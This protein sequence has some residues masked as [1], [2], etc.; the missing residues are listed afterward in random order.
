MCLL[1]FLKIGVTNAI[2][3]SDGNIP[4]L[5]D[6]LIIRERGID[7]CCDICFSREIDSLSWPELFFGFRLLKIFCITSWLI[8]LN[9]NLQLM[10]FLRYDLNE[11]L[12]ALLI[13]LASLGPIVEKY[14]LNLLAISALS[15][16][17]V[18]LYIKYDGKSHFLVVLFRREFI[19]PHVF[20]TLS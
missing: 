14:S 2:L 13:L 7:M 5:R 15:V 1:P 3:S 8:C 12:P 16:S 11:P 20:L 19:A 9:L 18:S 17:L 4:V 10:F 6:W